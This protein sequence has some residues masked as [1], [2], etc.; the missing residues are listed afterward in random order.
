MSLL[1]I[2][3]T[4]VL[5]FTVPAAWSRVIHVAQESSGLTK[6]GSTWQTAYSDLQVALSGAV[7]GDEIWVAEGTYR[8]S[9][10]NP[11]ISFDLRP[12]VA[13][14]GGFRGTESSRDERGP[15]DLTILDGAEFTWHVVNADDTVGRDRW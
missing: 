3:I 6:D 13:V 12:G 1:R 2:F 15:G 14:Y 10:T 5:V 4:I 9:T 11:A 8:P 7:A